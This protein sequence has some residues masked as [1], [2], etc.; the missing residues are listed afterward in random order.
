[1]LGDPV[2]DELLIALRQAGSAGMSRTQIRDLYGRNQSGA[3]ITRALST[4]ERQHKAKKTIRTTGV[5]G[6]PGEIWAAI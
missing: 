2:T 6:R 5:Q 1:M 3:W 4:L